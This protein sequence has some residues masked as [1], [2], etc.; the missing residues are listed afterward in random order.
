MR[1]FGR[2]YQ[3]LMDNIEHRRDFRRGLAIIVLFFIALAAWI[4]ISI[5]YAGARR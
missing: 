1:L 2:D 3:R 5:L 4:V